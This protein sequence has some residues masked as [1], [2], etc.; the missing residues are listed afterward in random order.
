M[1]EECKNRAFAELKWRSQNK[2]SSRPLPD[3]KLKPKPNL[4][5]EGVETFL[6]KD[7]RGYGVR[8]MRSFEPRQIIVEYI[9]EIITQDESDRR[10]NV[11]YKE[12]SVS[13]D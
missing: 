5:G 11:D 2:N 8:A 3:D 6:T 9:G 1:G 13:T 10:M 4:Y 12:K 7:N